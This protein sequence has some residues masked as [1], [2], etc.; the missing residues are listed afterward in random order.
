MRPRPGTVLDDPRALKLYRRIDF[1]FEERFGQ[2]HPLLAQLIP[3][4]AAAFDDVVRCFLQDLPNGTVVAL[5]E[6]LET[7]FWR[8]GRMQWLPV[9]LDASMR[10]RETLVPSDERRKVLSCDARDPRWVA[11]VPPG[12]PVLVTAQGLLMYLA[13]AGGPRSDRSGCAELPGRKLRLRRGPGWFAAATR[14]MRK[15]DRACG[16][17][18]PEKW[19]SMNANQRPCCARRTLPSPECSACPYRTD[20]G[21]S[22][23]GL[24]RPWTRSRGTCPRR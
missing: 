19:W 4:R 7:G 11:A 10:L 1:P 3:L 5:G 6:G 13:A 15:Q 16:Y 17:R 2:A 21:C 9:D 12:A 24:C 20:R 14:R 23:G 18:L 8:V 22:G